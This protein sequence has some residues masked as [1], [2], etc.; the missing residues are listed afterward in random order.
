MPGTL[1]R[2]PDPKTTDIVCPIRIVTHAGFRVRPAW[3]RANG[4]LP[5]LL[6][7]VCPPDVG[8]EPEGA[9]LLRVGGRSRR[10]VSAA[11]RPPDQYAVLRARSRVETTSG[12]ISSRPNG[13]TGGRRSGRGG[14]PRSVP[15]RVPQPQGRVQRDG[16]RRG[17]YPALGVVPPGD[18]SGIHI[19]GP[20]EADSHRPFMV[21]HRSDALPSCVA[22]PGDYR[23][24]DRGV[25]ARGCGRWA[26][27]SA[28]P[29][30]T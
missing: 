13:E 5:S 28:T 19:C 4:R 17:A 21:S 8:G 27:T 26:S 11:T 10:M 23:A 12:S 15:S 3:T 18:G 30:N 29:R 16:P 20:A 1:G 25:H 6:V 14:N 9:R 7:A 22:V 24:Q 2:A